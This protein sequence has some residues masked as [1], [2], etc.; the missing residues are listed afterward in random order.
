M[1]KLALFTI[2]LF[3]TLV[4][5]QNLTISSTGQTGTSGTN[6]SL[7]DNGTTVTITNTGTATINTS[8]IEGYLNMGRN[9]MVTNSTSGTWNIDIN[10]NI[11]KTSSATNRLTFRS[12]GYIY[13]KDNVA[14]KSTSGAMDVI[15]WADA[16]DSQ[17]T[18]NSS[19]DEI[20]I[21][22][23]VSID[24]RGG[25]IVL[26]GGLDDGNNEGVANDGIP[27]NYAFRGSGDA[28]GAVN[29]G[30]SA[31][32]G[33]V[34]SLLSSGGEIIIRGYTRTTTSQ[35]PG[36]VT[37]NNLVIN[38]GTG[39][40][41][42]KG[43]S[44][45]SHGIE[46][47]YG[48]IPNIAITSDYSGVGPAI[49]IEGIAVNNGTAVRLNNT[50]S[51]NLLIQ[52]T[53]STGGG[54]SISGDQTTGSGNRAVFTTQNGSNTNL[55]ILS[56]SGDIFL[57]TSTGGQG[58]IYNNG[59]IYY[60]IRKDANP[61]QGITP[62]VT[63]SNA[64]LILQGNGVDFDGTK[65][66]NVVTTGKF[67]VLPKD[68]DNSFGYATTLRNINLGS[69]LSEV[70]IGKMTNTAD[71]TI[72]TDITV[73]G[74]ISIMGGYVELNGNITS[75]AA[76]D[77][78]FQ[79][80]GTGWSFLLNTGKTISK[81]AGY[82]LL[83]IQGNGRINDR[84]KVGDISA[85]GTGKLDVVMIAELDNGDTYGVTTGNITTN[86]GHLWI[87]GGSKTN[88][89]N[90]LEVGSKWS[91]GGNGGNVRG[92]EISG[93]LTTNGGDLYMAGWGYN[94]NWDIGA[95]S[96]DKT[97][98]TGAGNVTLLA[99]TTR[100]GGSTS[101]MVINT[102][103]VFSLA[104]LPGR[105]FGLV[106]LSVY[107]STTSGNFVG[108]D[109]VIGLQINSIANLSGLVFGNYFGTRNQDDTPYTYANATIADISTPFNIN[110]QIAV[111][112]S[113]VA[114][115]SALQSAASGKAIQ[116]VATGGNVDL[117][118]NLTATSPGA[119][120]LTKATADITANASR[121]FQTNN[122]N[123]IFWSDADNNGT[124]YI[125]IGDNNKFN[126]ANGLTT[127]G[128]SG[129]GKIV[130]AGGL[131]DGA[132]GGTA[133]DGIPD[134]TTKNGT[135]AGLV[136]GSSTSS[137]TE[138]YSGGGDIIV[139][140]T[141]TRATLD[142]GSTGLFSWGR[143]LA[144]SGKG[145]ITIN[146]SSKGYFGINFVQQTNNLTSGDKHLQLISDKISG[147]AISI[148][149]IST[150]N[151]GV[152]FNYN[153]PKEILA[154]GGGDIEI[155]GT[156]GGG[157]Q[158]IFIQ[159]Q[160][161]LASNG[162]I[163]LNGGVSGITVKSVGTR[164]GS[165]AGTDI[166]S[167]ASNI[168]WI[169]DAI[170]FDALSTGFSNNFNTSGT[171]TIEP[172]SNS[173]T[174]ALTYPITNL[175]LANTVSGLTLGKATNTQNITFGSAVSIAGP[176]TAYGGTINANANL[177]ST[178]TT[179]S[180]VLLSGQKIEQAAGVNVTTSG[181]NIDYTASNLVTTASNDYAI[182]L[183]A[184][185]GTK[186][187]INAQGGSISL[188]G[189]YGSTGIAGEGDFAIWV[190]GTDIKTNN[191]GTINIT[192]DATN[193]TT[194]GSSYGINLGSAS[195]IQTE[196]GAITMT[197]TGGKVT[198]NSRGIVVDGQALSI[199]SSS[200][201]ITLK[202]L[203]PANLT[204]TY[205]GFYLKPS[206]TADIFIGSDG[207]T[208]L[209][210]TSKNSSSDIL[211][212][213]DLLTFVQN[214]K[215]SNF[216][217]AGKITFEPVS[218]SFSSALTFPI[219]N[220][221]LANTISGLTLGKASNTANITFGS[222]TTIA[223]PIKA[224]GGTIAVN[225]ALTATNDNITLA[226]S[227]AITQTAAIT[228]NGL[229]LTGVG[230]A[231]LTNTSNAIN[232]LAGGAPATRMGA[233]NF[234]NNKA[235]T[236]G[237]VNPTGIYSSGAIE[238]ATTSGDLLVTEPINST[239]ATGDAIKLYA[240]KDA[241][242][243]AAG[244]GN[245]KISGNGSVTVASGARALLYS[246]RETLST[247]VT[248]AVGGETNVRFAVDATTALSSITPALGTTGK[249]ALY[250]V[251]KTSNIATLA[252]LTTSVG[253]ISPT[254]AS[255]TLIYTNAIA[256]TT[257]SFSFTPTLT[258]GGATL[259]VND[260]A[261]ASGTAYA[262][263]LTASSTTFTIKVVSSDGTVTKIY[264]LNVLKQLGAVP[265]ASGS[266]VNLFTG[267][268]FDPNDDQQAT[269]ETDIVGNAS[270]PM[271]QSQQSY[272]NIN[273][274]VEKVY[275]FRVRLANAIKNNGAP[276][277]TSFYYAFDLT[278]DQK[279][280]MVV[281]AN[282]KSSTPYVSYH[283]QD[284]SK[285]G[286]GPSSTAWMNSS[287]NINV[288]RKLTTA[289]S[290]IRY[291]AVTPEAN[292][293]V[294]TDLDAP[295][296]GSNTGTDTWLEFAFTESSF[297]S[298]TSQA[299]NKTSA[300]SDVV[301]M[302]AFTSTSQ[303]ANGDIGGINDKTA[304]MNLTWAQLGVMLTTS[305][306]KVTQP[307]VLDP[308][309]VS[310][311]NTK[312]INGD[313]RVYGTWNGDQYPNALLTVKIYDLDGV[314]VKNTFTYNN[315][316]STATG[317]IST[318]GF[319]WYVDV[320]GYTPGSYKVEATMTD[321]S[322]SPAS[323]TTIGTLLVSH[324]KV[325]NLITDDTTPTI[326][327]QT[328]QPAGVT[329]TMKLYDSNNTLLGTYTTQTQSD[330]SWSI[331]V[332]NSDAL[333]VG[334]YDINAGI[335]IQTQTNSS[336][337]YDEITISIVNSPKIN[338]TSAETQTYGA[339][340]L[341]GGTNQP[342]NATIDVELTD[343]DGKVF[344]YTTTT[345]ASG[346]WTINLNTLPAGTYQIYGAVTDANGLQSGTT[347]VLTVNKKGV[348]ISGLTANNKVY[349]G[350][351][352]ATVTGT[353]SL[354]GAVT[355]STVTLSG[356]PVYTFSQHDVANALVVT[357]SGY[358]LSGA[359]A[360]NYTLTQPSLSANITKASLV[361]TAT[362]KSKT[363]GAVDPTLEV[364]YAG[365]VNN[366]TVTNLGGSLTIQRASG[367]TVGTYAITAS[368]FTS[369][370][371]TI[372]Y[373]PGVFTIGAKLLSSTDISV[374][375]V[376]DQIYNGLN[377][378]PTPMVYDKGSL[379]TVGTHYTVSS[380]ASNK[381]VGTATITLTG[382]GNYS[383]TKT[384]TFQI[385]KA[386]LTVKA[387]DKSKAFGETDP[388]N[389]VTYTGFVNNETS[390]VLGGTLTYSRASGESIG[391]YAITPAGLTST[392]Y[393]ITYATG[394]L[395]ISGKD[396]A[397][398]D[399][400]VGALASVVYQGTPYTPSV[401]VTDGSTT[402]ALTTDYT[403]TYSDNINA[404]TATVTITG[405]G[406]YSGTRTVTFSITKASLTITAQA[407]TKT[408]G[409]V[410]PA[411]TVTY[412][413]FVNSETNAN[414]NGALS[415]VRGTQ[416]NVGVYAASII[417]SGYTSNNYT[418]SYIKG[419]FTITAKSIASGDISIAPIA[420][421]VYKGTA[422]TPEPIVKDGTKVLVKD[423]DYTL[424]YSNNTYVGTAT[425]TVTGKGNYDNTTSQTINFTITKAP[426]TIT[427][428]NKSKLTGQADPTLTVSYSGFVNGESDAVVTKPTP[429]ATRSAGETPGSYTI[430]AGTFSASNYSITYN[431]G[432]L[433]ISG[434]NINS[435]TVSPLPD[436][437]YK[438]SAYTDKPTIQYNSTTLTEGTDYTLTYSDNLNVGTASVLITGKGQYFGYK[439]ITFNIN[440]V[441][442]TITPDAGQTKVYG[443]ADPAL[444][445]TKSQSST[446]AGETPAFTGALSR[447]AGESVASSPYAIN[448]GNLALADNGTFKA[449][450]YDIQLAAT[451]VNFT[452]TKARLKAQI[453]NDSKFVNK[454]DV[455]G[456]AGVTYTG[457]AFGEN[458]TT[459]A[460]DESGLTISRSGGQEVAGFYTD[461]LFGWGSSAANYDFDFY[462]GSYTIIPADQLLVQIGNVSTVYGTEPAYT[463]QSAKYLKT[464]GTTIVDLISTPTVVT[465][466]VTITDPAG[467][468]AI[469]DIAVN[470]PI[471]SSAN[472]LKVG[473]YILTP[474]NIT[475]TSDNFSNTIVLQGNLTVTPKALTPSVTGGTT[476]VYDGNALMKDFVLSL[477]T[478]E[479]NDVVSAIGTGT[480]DAGKDV[481]SSKA[482]TVG[483]ISLSGA[484]AGNYYVSGNAVG[485]G[486]ITAKTLTVTPLPNQSKVFGTS[487]PT[488]LFN[489]T[490]A[491]DGETPAFT[492]A[493]TRVAGETAGFYDIV[494]GNLALATAGSFLS[495]NYD[496]SFTQNV[497]FA[498]I[499]K[500]IASSSI[501]VAS[502]PS[503]VYNGA[504]Q[505]ST[506]E[507]KD[508]G[509][510][511]TAGT[512]YNIT[513]YA[514]NKDVGTA[515]VTIT[516]IG[517]YSGTRTATFQITPAPLIIK[518]VNT[519]KAY[520][521]ADPTFTVTYSG[522]VGNPL[523]TSA[524]L[525]GTLSFAGGTTT[526]TGV[527]KYVIT[528]SGLSSSNYT[529]TYE[530]GLLEITAKDIT[531]NGT[532]T[533]TGASDK[534]YNG[535][536]QT[537]TPTVKD[538]STT[539]TLG[540]DYTL[541]YSNNVN[542]GTATMTVTG[543]GNYT[544]TQTVN[545]A[546]TPAPLTITAVNKSKVYR[547]N[548]P[549][550]T[551]SY[552][553]FVNGETASVLTGTLVISRGSETNVGVYANTIEASGLSATN[554]TITYVK[555]DFTITQKSIAPP[556]T[557][558]IDP[559]TVDPIADVTYKGSAYEPEPAVYD[560]A[561]KLIKDTDYTLSYS[562]SVNA[563]TATI[564][565]TGK[566][567]YTNTRTVNFVIIKAPLK[568]TA[569]DKAKVYGTLDPT[570]TESFDSFVGG[571][572]VSVLTPGQPI[573]RVSGENL[574]IYAI[575]PGTY[576]SSNYEISYVAGTLAISTKLITS[577]DVTVS[578]IA[579]VVYNG[580]SQSPKPIVKDGSTTLI[581][582]TH[583]VL[584]YS[585]NTNAGTVTVTIS[586]LG[587]YSGTRTTTFAITK[588]PL[589]ITADNKTKEF[590]AS[591]PSLTVSFSG[592]VNNETEA[593]LGGSLAISRVSG[594]NQGTYTITPSGYTSDNYNISYVTGTFTISAKLIT[595]ADIAIASLPNVTYKGSAYTPDPIVTDGTITLIKDID[596][597]L[598]YSANINAGTATITITGIGNYSGTRTVTFVITK[599]LLT[600]TAE[601][602][603]KLIGSSDPTLTVA[604]SGLVTGETNAVLGGTL[605][606]SRAPGENMGTYAITASGL[607]ST[608][609]QISFQS[610]IFSIGDNVPPTV[611]T[612]N[613]TV[614][615]DA[616]G[617]VSITASDV[618]NG[619]S[620]S[621]GIFNMTV[622]PS[623]FTCT[624]VG[625][626]TVT[627][628][629]I[630]FNGNVATANVIVTVV[631]NYPDTDGDGLK[632]NCDD[633]DD[634]D[635]LT[636]VQEQTLGTNPLNP[637]SDGDG[638]KD[639][640]EIADGT[641]ANDSCK[642]VLAH[643]TLTPSA[644]WN[645]ADCD[646]D[647]VTNTQE[648]LDGTDPLN[649][650]SDGDGVIDG[651][652]KADGTDAKDGC[653]FIQAHQTVATSTT[654]NAA[655]CDGDGTTNRQEIL[656]NTDPLIGDTDGDG[657]LD[658]QEI[659]DG[660]NKNNSCEFLLAHQTL[661]PS[662]AWNT[663]DCD[664]DGVTN[665]QEKA[666]GTNPLKADTDG[667]GVIDGKEKTDTTDAKDACKFKLASQTVAPSTAWNTSDC[668]G[669][670]L[671]N[672]QEKTLGTDPLKADTDGD[673]ISDGVEKLN[674]TNPLITDTDN[675]GIPDNL[676]NCPL[677]PNANQADNDNDG[678][679]DVCDA[680]DD[681]D[682]V[683]DSRDNCPFIPN[684]N[685]AD[686]D[687]DGKG[688]V[689]DTMELN[690][691]EAI[692]PNGDGI[693]DTWVIYN[694]E[695]YPGTIIR[696]FNR[697][698]AEVF[699]SRDYKNDWDGHYNNSQDALPTSASYLY[700]IDL[701][702]DGTIDLQGWL[703]LTH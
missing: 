241:A 328:D 106:D 139:R 439:T 301:G 292:T 693:N 533:I 57:G 167:S 539:L 630:D 526:S 420:D 527:G 551:V 33:T 194:T 172:F 389:S 75:T 234:T 111:Y 602:K 162:K 520:G 183:G 48:G 523:E 615:L 9:V 81:T 26:A 53:A 273:G 249:Y 388:A 674:G 610:G 604:Y 127:S 410:D 503:V 537:Q 276:P 93:N 187:S 450:N 430:T 460:I 299:L 465:N 43:F 169:A 561:I 586:G 570:L 413:G 584:G 63:T 116:V 236:V 508:G 88:K 575:T 258:D 544:G 552:S 482:F 54:I 572:T 136:L 422:Y 179:G 126:S 433:V 509:T 642:F 79:G 519:T 69:T 658:P 676:D 554:Y 237:S 51:G 510:T 402:L 653:K 662:A 481:G 449:S 556:I 120:I 609:Y 571:E 677:T 514:N 690:V 39:R 101:R 204:G 98:S 355:G 456:Y 496:L 678:Q 28:L 378:T 458:K 632:D 274:T 324:I 85:S 333:Q 300:G 61:I 543:I 252:S 555:G 209:S 701:N 374:A 446:I 64:N 239:L 407:K 445:Y 280:D 159:N 576:T 638:V 567:N 243:G 443:S 421:V 348:T 46:F 698:G 3:S 426:L 634:N 341:T 257:S 368:G 201:K 278:K 97:I 30:P 240:D 303:T 158:G 157:W 558:V 14:I 181:A 547:A 546:I 500:D 314:T 470:S 700:Q 245:I 384:V 377:Q 315:A 671:T 629:V 587:D 177:T 411:L 466:P 107:G 564:T 392:N 531:P 441:V 188:S 686:R 417:P 246:G 474:S 605:V 498:I 132:N 675:D 229:A 226:A 366:E 256:S 451:T 532:L 206:S 646:N 651:T 534:V 235:L 597:T 376:P 137:Y 231:T 142:L 592:F 49:Q 205:T 486:A 398:N 457:F 480:Y 18:T 485:T 684:P 29:L 178:A 290:E 595:D 316:T 382:T 487:D 608:N 271:A 230:S 363:F 110:G 160:D 370:N 45:Y 506:L 541:S 220:L 117:K 151:Y 94:T 170:N 440:P 691:S 680:D 462:N 1:K 591:D 99:Q 55:Q 484:D 381:D 114:I 227:T 633:D 141:S 16:D 342:A 641:D 216:N 418:I 335:T 332:P 405:A 310:V 657:V 459:A 373:V 694:I 23:G 25:K 360:G 703:Y 494:Q 217:T 287:N 4:S 347:G 666:D 424:S 168:K 202:D 56:G 358:T 135:T 425:V 211:I 516:G 17:K 334:N 492:G 210:G 380:Y 31:G 644:A 569:D 391:T 318:T 304:N 312:S 530:T 643:Q 95:V 124:G 679:G 44:T 669:D 350:T 367:E 305:L 238:I 601:N 68:G 620:D 513:S 119:S 616:N 535:I 186:A 297:Q 77:L 582:G 364:T 594:Q 197:G 20:N 250:R 180:G 191:N 82:G 254:F 652:E 200:G 495:G 692:T 696:V 40:I 351:L 401:T 152:V 138:M 438:G 695:N 100:L 574:G 579:D 390:A 6:W 296:S 285:D 408:Y 308:L 499:N 260:V 528:P 599:A 317:L 614:Y 478:A 637:D 163:T 667:D 517:D 189:S 344:T 331:T 59:L 566:G 174:S 156:G 385:V 11:T 665:A 699:Y 568:I 581:E 338:I 145:S 628:T 38:S 371:Y 24:T 175:T 352:T 469:F 293:T 27:D 434:I 41:I 536:P 223:G 617:Q 346:N 502:I 199:L 291:Y 313:A 182:K 400:S 702:G 326:T 354:V 322:A 311:I 320:T 336:E 415:I 112:G 464:D 387:D 647:G 673:G 282:A 76:G 549:T 337:S 453:N 50:T 37:Q 545:F 655:D 362:D 437:I 225:G 687:Q 375:A 153:N 463:I 578:T 272:V 404:G 155:N 590:G 185:T 557:S 521:A 613:I 672:T 32:T 622:A 396:I 357:T 562:N 524:N 649:P 636:D 631:N 668:D 626:N 409:A 573:S 13:I 429:L 477:A 475:E 467:G 192:G 47:S 253:T 108:T 92:I 221:T 372:S 431:T 365:F 560:G 606:I 65:L 212:Q 323:A 307:V 244:D 596:Y 511:L 427:A 128:L 414:L 479:T 233:L 247:G 73:N 321:N 281:E 147:T 268:R 34:I 650:D 442:I 504:D 165:R 228:A 468:S 329:V 423:T 131:D 625:A 507:V 309:T 267:A 444:T 330:G 624:N 340:S 140:G 681:N 645:T 327:G 148:T 325:D 454:P 683:L 161:I 548:D 118:A 483:G 269:A 91:S 84:D 232:T 266:W 455:T 598:G 369:I 214:T 52:S 295:V 207:S 447:A 472:K 195:L 78:F 219:T 262:T 488:L 656:N 279:I 661:A 203:K 208:V 19:S 176:I 353:A 222:A 559:I 379:L 102:T 343:A 490:G 58:R 42:M 471:Y 476:K 563:G 298:F 538:G 397:S 394:K 395:T 115:N 542:V 525:T 104:P 419:D 522:F 654:W 412:S 659:L 121:T 87:G 611:I 122:G 515:T 90:G 146:G 583:Y 242:V 619:S 74:P 493:L 67:S 173:F 689:C 213:S 600:I 403:V 585:S 284:P 588:A 489:A 149:G 89:W 618:D 224:Y 109:D 512:H 22:A 286:S 432:E 640:T 125:G 648:K 196:F 607:T 133:D 623:T 134:G 248:T 144:N 123:L 593:K 289:S 80:L 255:E 83:T 150:V 416:E 491:V 682:G 190:H 70:T 580:L 428:D 86:R 270:N 10:N 565:I 452:I 339:A 143:W 264:K 113:G 553:G 66:T 577:N 612:K 435:T 129:G 345:D 277:G 670:G 35:K 154:T 386:P 72:S 130:L 288:E 361:V 688:D 294:S 529:I 96:S 261:H 12:N 198:S 62:S 448:L 21:S 2:F 685:Q 71:I 501:T 166:T 505:I 635:G 589:T 639:G 36:I 660:T 406:N 319:S 15:L 8:V 399:I 215:I 356:T 218:N 302:V 664:N 550:L 540:T 518:A 603:S 627:F 697:W 461:V 621:G 193:T 171:V 497:K 259:T 473:N 663:S 383:G 306:D 263:T 251:N 105:D 164:V 436:V 265:A 275:Y 393:T 60:G 103:G 283:I 5:A 359:D 7:T 349:D 184:T